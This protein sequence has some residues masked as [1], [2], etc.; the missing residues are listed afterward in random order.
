M[1]C[2]ALRIP[3]CGVKPC[4]D[5]D[6]LGVELKGQ[7]QQH[8]QEGGHVICVSHP[9]LVP[10]QVDREAKAPPAAD[11][12][13][14]RL[15]QVGPEAPVLI[16]VPGEVKDAGVILK[17]ILGA[18]TM[19]D[20]PVNDE[21][22]VQSMFLLGMLGCYGHT[23][24]HAESIGGGPLAVVPRRPHQGETVAHNSRHHCIHQLQSSPCGQPGTVEGTRM[25]VDGVELS[26]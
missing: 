20:V 25:E 19:V 5:Q 12:V 1:D 16:A 26:G 4:G 6:Q 7:G 14:I 22:P 9:D 10:G 15:S 23:I 8:L 17:D 18:L 2:R 21:D 3:D 13:C 24:E 11:G